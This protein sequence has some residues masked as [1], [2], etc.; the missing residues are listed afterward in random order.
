[1]TCPS[2]LLDMP[3]TSAPPALPL[4]RG[5]ERP[6]LGLV[7]LLRTAAF[8]LSVALPVA[9]PVVLLASL[10]TLPLLLGAHVLA[11]TVG[12]GHQPGGSPLPT[13]TG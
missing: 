13:E 6:V 1:M 12:H 8:W 3:D 2:T 5:L 7:A 11:V 10:E 4:P 9:Y